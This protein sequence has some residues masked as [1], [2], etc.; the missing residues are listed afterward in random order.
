MAMRNSNK[1]QLIA[2][3]MTLGL[4]VTMLIG[5]TLAWFTD[6]ATSTGNKIE[7]G[8]LS[9]DL[10]HH[11][12]DKE[13]SIKDNPQ[14]KIFNYDK[15]EP[16]YTQVETLTI[17]NT[18]TLALQY[19]MNAV[20][21]GEESNNGKRLSDVIDV[22]MSFGE[23]TVNSMEEISNNGKWCKIGTLTE[24]LYNENLTS[25]K[26]LP[27]GEQGADLAQGITAGS[28]TVTVALHMQESAGN[29]YQGL[30]LGDIGLVLNATQWTYENDSFNNQYD[31]NSAYD[32]VKLTIGKVRESLNNGENVTFAKDITVLKDEVVSSPYGV[33]GIMHKGNV[34]DGNG[35]TLT[36]NGANSSYGSVIY[37]T[38]GTIKNLTVQGAF[39]GIF[40][41][42]LT[43]DLIIDN[44]TFNDVTYTFNADASGDKNV[45]FKNSTLNGWTSYTSGFKGVSF[46]NCKFGEGRGYAFLRP[47]SPTILSN[48]EF[49]E[50]FELDATKT[51]GIVL[52]NCTV[53]G[54][55]ITEDNIITLL[56]KDAANA[57]VK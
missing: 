10:L 45:I 20:L 26:I 8:S 1:K 33:T 18:G 57:E 37:T 24:W 12:N 21:N 39:R 52:E 46:T 22:Y 56:G 15:W 19:K 40:T 47:Y 41:G 31:Q 30:S 17:K 2:S 35:K 54:K 32:N 11:K 43:S 55:L 53:N 23:N 25:G 44:V 42:G 13:I 34:I 48:C 7:A 6:T 16:G 4:S 5:T 3:V 36:V 29:E 28:S 49:S 50:G 14:H 27:V 38:G 9:I 51:S